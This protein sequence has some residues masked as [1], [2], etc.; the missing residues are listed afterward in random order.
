ML[1]V[2]IFL[3][4]FIVPEMIVENELSS[5]H[6]HDD[7][8]IAR[9]KVNE[10]EFIDIKTNNN[11]NIKKKSSV[12][13]EQGSHYSRCIKSMLEESDDEACT[14]EV[15]EDLRKNTLVDWDDIHQDEEDDGDRDRDDVEVPRSDLNHPSSSTIDSSNYCGHGPFPT[16]ATCHME[17]PLLPGCQVQSLAEQ[18]DMMTVRQIFPIFLENPRGYSYTCPPHNLDSPGNP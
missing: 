9:E 1:A 18:L 2:F 11:M 3:L 15:K 13:P 17:F 5:S 12:F 6:R 10:L 14:G 8:L 16:L 7:T 4:V